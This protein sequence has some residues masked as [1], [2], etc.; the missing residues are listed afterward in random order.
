MTQGH[1]T[2]LKRIK[3]RAAHRGIKEMD[4]ILGGWAQDNIGALGDG[5]LDL[6]ERILEESDHDLYQWV[7]G[8]RAA[9]EDLAPLLARIAREFAQT[10]GT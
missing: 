3:M 4:I 10:R 8:Q 5:D 9:P 1:E 6:F 7:T 2:R